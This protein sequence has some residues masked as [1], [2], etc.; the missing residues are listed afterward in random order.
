M[1]I[2]SLSTMYLYKFTLTIMLR[3]LQQHTS[4]SKLIS[5]YYHFS[6]SELNNDFSMKMNFLSLF[7][8]VLFLS[9][10]FFLFLR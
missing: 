3:I 5:K 10:E 6:L 2:I 8:G 7:Y 1:K 9:T 4:L